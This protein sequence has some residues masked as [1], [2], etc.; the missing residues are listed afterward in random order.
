VTLSLIVFNILEITT[1]NLN[2]NLSSH[3][4]LVDATT[5]SINIAMANADWPNVSHDHQG[6]RYGKKTK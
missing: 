3:F 1:F 2:V 5:S 4:S 6:S